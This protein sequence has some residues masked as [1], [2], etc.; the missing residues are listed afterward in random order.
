MSQLRKAID[1]SM[2]GEGTNRLGFGQAASREKQRAMLLGVIERDAESA[3][4]ALDAGAELVILRANDVRSAVEALQGIKET[5]APVGA[6]ISDLDGEGA[7]SLANAGADFVASPLD[8]TVA[9]AV[10]TERMGQVVAVTGD[11]EE[12]TLRALSNLDLDALFVKRPGGRMTLQQQVELARL[13]MLSGSPLLVSSPAEITA[14]ELRVLRDAG[15]VAVVAADG[16][17]AD[18]I[19]GLGERLREVKPRRRPERRDGAVA[20]VPATGRGHEHDHDDD[21][22]DD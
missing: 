4:A 14:S 20:L 10:D 12:G 11:I 6:W 18:E 16:A 1:R 2:R 8:G 19:K 3:N 7:E 22:D 21:D 5:K 9:D 15:A 13:T 17:T